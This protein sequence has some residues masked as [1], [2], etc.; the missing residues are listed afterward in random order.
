VALRR[1]W[2]GPNQVHSDQFSAVAL[3]DAF[4]RKG[5]VLT[6]EPWTLQTKFTRYTLARSLL[7]DRRMRL[8]DD[9]AL[10]KELGGIG[11]KLTTAGNE[12]ISSRGGTDDRASA[13]VHVAY[14]CARMSPGF[15]VYDGDT[16]V[17][18]N[19]APENPG[20]PPGSRAGE[21]F[22][23]HGVGWLERLPNGGLTGAVEPRLVAD[24]LEQ[25]RRDAEAWVREEAERREAYAWE[26]GQSPRQLAQTEPDPFGPTAI[27]PKGWTEWPK[28]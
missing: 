20:P 21:V 8:P 17:E 27:K 28:F 12:T 11:L 13:L 1:A 26:G 3:R 7:V 16:P 6:T 5:V 4:W 25:S 22:F 14:L 24:A 9:P 2:P 23:R 18:M 10:R 15:G 19:R